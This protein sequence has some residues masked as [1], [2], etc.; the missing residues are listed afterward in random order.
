MFLVTFGFLVFMAV[1]LAA[2]YLV[3][4]RWQWVLLLAAS[5]VFYF[6]AGTPYTMVYLLSTI[7]S[8][9]AGGNYIDKV[10][11]TFPAR[12]RKVLVAVLVLN[13][14]ILA[15][16][17]YTNFLISNFNAAC[18]LFG[19]ENRIS[20]VQWAASLGVSFYTLQAVGYLLDV[21]WGTSKP[22]ANIFK[23]ALFTSYFPQMSSGPISRY[24]QLSEQLYASHKFDYQRVCFGLWRMMFGFV[25]K[26]VIA[27]NLAVYV[28]II[29]QDTENYNGWFIWLGMAGYIIQLYT[30]F[31]GCMDI[32]LGA[33]ECFGIKLPENFDRP[34]HSKSIQEFW[35]RWHI[36]LGAWVQDYIMFPILHS[37]AWGKMRRK[38]KSK[39]GKYAA[40][41]IP[42]YLAMLILWFFMGL[43]HGGAWRYI[44]QNLWFWAVIMLGQI[45]AKPL[46]RISAVLC[47]DTKSRLWQCFQSI[48]TTFIFGVGLVFFRASSARRGWHYLKGAFSPKCLAVS[49]FLVQ[50]DVYK[51]SIVVEDIWKSMVCIGFGLFLMGILVVFK[52][53]GKSF[54]VWLSGR[55]IVFRW[56]VL[57]MILFG[58]ILFGV[59]GPEYNA[60]EFI[61]GGF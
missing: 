59:Y 56:A 58:I 37:K 21:Y 14:G 53:R 41:N 3:P 33:S 8:V 48:R 10:R 42:T 46:K 55:N 50:L 51:G 15:V 31:S 29:F 35:K 54:R 57:Y 17:K 9:W 47:I 45:F 19:G 30:D 36:T 25:K 6:Y 52:A 12:A 22:Q 24:H 20:T 1:T 26:L 60:S 18:G 39:Y 44:V 27:E 43:W 4:E 38:L 32:V 16:L 11:E 2:Y 40:K 28:N 34:F 23:V 7:V 5:M 49:N 13:I 61:Y